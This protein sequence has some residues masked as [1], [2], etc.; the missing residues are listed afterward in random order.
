MR[1]DLSESQKLDGRNDIK[2]A[3]LEGQAYGTFR[4]QNVTQFSRCNSMCVANWK[5]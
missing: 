2:R 4:E 3:E 1:E 5:Q